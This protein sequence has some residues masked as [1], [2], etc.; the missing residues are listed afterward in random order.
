MII[1]VTG[2]C[3]YLGSELIRELGRKYPN[4]TI[5]ILDNMMRERH[6]SL[7]DLPTGPTYQM[8]EGDIR[9]DEDLEKAIKGADVVFSLSDL[10]NAPK[11]FKN[12]E[13]TED[14]NFRGVM[15]ILDACEKHKVEKFIYS[16]TA[17][18]YGTTSGIVDETF[19]CKPLSPYGIQKL[20]V[21]K[22]ILKRAKEKNLNYTALRLGTVVGWTIGMR[23]DTV[24]DRFTYLACI[25]MPITI[26]ESALNEARPY[27]HVKDVIRAYLFAMENTEKMKGEAYNVVAENKGLGEVVEIL[28]Q[29]FSNLQSEITKKGNLN[30]VSYKLSSEKIKAIG[31]EFEHTINEG[32]S[33]II[34]KFKGIT[35]YIG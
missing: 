21:E 30:Q 1:L 28:K 31:F 35:P 4:A 19:D 25:G 5:R 22:E 13:L 32:I 26:W 14:I 18:V 15:K 6:V 10:T 20:R 9:N 8:I 29:N 33:D 17:S 23:F 2:G 34:K 12:K 7:W 11:S 24:I 16:S 3:G 27:S